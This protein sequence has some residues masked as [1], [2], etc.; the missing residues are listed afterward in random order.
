MKATA[1]LLTKLQAAADNCELVAWLERY[2]HFVDP[3]SEAF[4]KK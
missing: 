4:L 3:V 1:L 2:S